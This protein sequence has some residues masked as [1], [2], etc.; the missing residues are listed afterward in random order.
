[1]V[2]DRRTI[3]KELLVGEV[4]IIEGKKFAV[5]GIGDIYALLEVKDKNRV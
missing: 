1:M 2:A 3:E 4:V 5:Y